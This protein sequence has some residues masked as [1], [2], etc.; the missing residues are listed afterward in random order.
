MITIRTT[1]FF[2]ILAVFSSCKDPK[3]GV[4]VTLPVSEKRLKA[5]SVTAK[6][7]VDAHIPKGFVLMDSIRGDLNTDGYSDLVL[8]LRT[9]G[10]DTASDASAYKRPLL[11]LTGLPDQNYKLAARNDDLVYCY[12][13][14]GLFGD[15][16]NGLEINNGALSLNHF[17]GSNLRWSNEFVFRYSLP[18]SALVLNKIIDKS[19]SVFDIEKIHSTVKTSVDFGLITLSDFRPN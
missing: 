3:A 15:P 13:C 7:G 16:Y 6:G 12:Q 19:W 2:L 18:D 1:I 5:D 10:E 11:I 9:P 17:G 14:G 4:E 8:V